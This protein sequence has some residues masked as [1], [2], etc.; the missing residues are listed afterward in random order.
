MAKWSWRKITRVAL[1]APVLCLL[2]LGVEALIAIPGPDDHFHNPDR[3][4][5]RLGEP[6][7]AWTYVVLGDSTGAGRGGH[8][9]TGIAMQTARHLARVRPIVLVN[10]AVSGAKVRDVERDQLPAALRLN[11]DVVLLAIGANDVTHFTSSGRIQAGL[12]T[13]LTALAQARPG[14]R[15][16]LTGS[17]DVG[18]VRRFAQPLRWVAGLETRRVNH[19][20]D[21]VI[22]A[23][24]SRRESVV[25]A[26]IA[27]DIG[28]Q[29]RKD[30]G[31][32]APDRFHPNDRGYALWVPVLNAALDKLLPA[33]DD[34]P[35]NA[36][37]P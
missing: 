22:A 27:E 35:Q 7:K 36:H 6:G 10:L 9:E 29:F 1:A 17:P 15:V 12:S 16:V 18:S 8:Y 19:V 33:S 34:K 28:P 14:V 20:V 25:L 13:I 26:P 37:H 30:A 11:P 32:L 31:L 21:A 23:A 3:K 5:V 2:V 4:P 24:Q